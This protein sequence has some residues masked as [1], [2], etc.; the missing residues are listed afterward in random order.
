M[1]NSPRWVAG[2]LA[3]IAVCGAAFAAGS[4]LL[5]RRDT[6]FN[7]ILIRRTGDV[8][9]MN[10]RVQRCEFVESQRDLADPSYLPVS[11]TRMMTA[12]LAYPAKLDSILEV[13]VGGGTT[14]SYLHR[15]LPDT[16]ITG[17]ELDPGVVE[18]AKA[19]FG[20][21]EDDRLRIAVADGRAFLAEDEGKHDLI[22]VDAYRGTWVPETLTSVEFFRIVE[23]RL[24][25][26]GVVAQNVEPTTLFYDGLA[27]T[28][29]AVF[30]HVDAYPTAADGGL[31]SNVVLVAY[32]G[33]RKS[34]EALMAR[35]EAL[36]EAHGFRH[37]LPALVAQ[38]RAAAIPNTAK[39]LQDASGGA[40]ALLMI[41]KANARDTPRRRR[42]EC[43]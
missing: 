15:F 41:D 37:P 31:A 40:N 19:H 12:A 5:E 17:V 25:P 6:E 35:A 33:P 24:A 11:Y 4:T 10:F 22:Y 13:G 1:L 26:G 27:A 32:D 30:D 23:K 8:V 20:L 18:L 38:G 28:L 9:S 34:R 29:R 21:T 36:Q 14:I 43:E 3:A 2:T 16:R 39:A 42:A 7:S